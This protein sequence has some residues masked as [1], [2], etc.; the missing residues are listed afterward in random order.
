MTYYLCK[1]TGP[2][3]T[4]PQDTPPQEAAIMQA[5]VAYCGEWF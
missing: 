1:L 4:L 5:H 3:P 2:R